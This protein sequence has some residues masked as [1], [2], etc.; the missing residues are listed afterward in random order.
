[1]RATFVYPNS[2]RELLARIERGDDPDSQLHGALYLGDHGIDVDFHDPLLTRRQLP[3]ALSRVAWNLRE[4]TTPFELGRTDVVFTPLAAFLPLAA[5][6]RRLPV[7]VINFGLN[8]IWRRAAR[9]RRVVLRRSLR[10]AARVICLG[11]AQRVELVD[12][13]GLEPHRVLTMPIPVDAQFFEPREAGG[14]RSVL[15]VGKDL[16]RDYGTFLEAVSPLAVEATVVAHPRNLAGLELPANTRLA[17]ATLP[18]TGLRDAYARA[19]CVVV[20][21]RGDDYAF[22]S[23]GGG[24]TA[25]L[26]AMA[27]GRPVVATDRAILH[28]YVED[29][30]HALLVPPEDPS[31]MRA[32]IERVLG[33]PELAHSL[34]L[35]ARARVERSHTS[36]GFA[37]RLAPVLES[38]VY[39]RRT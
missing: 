15:T 18:F 19:A 23:E 21:Q 6:G 37:A 27:M 4:L 11:E 26:E 12:A 31:A 24:L 36:P 28:D 17:P 16:A 32:A 14:A 20:P 5:R 35:A 9:A 38:V 22:G 39:A 13:A 34:G 8:L 30:V 25:L 3:N 2:R 7:V 29:G 33:D 10:A 1:M